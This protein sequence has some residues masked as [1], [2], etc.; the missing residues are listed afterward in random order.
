LGVGI[1]LATMEIAQQVK[2]KAG[3][4]VWVNSVFEGDPAHRAGIRIGDVILKIGGT[5]V[6]TPGRMIRLIGAFSPGQSVN[7]DILRDGR[8]EVV[9]VKLGNQ[10]KKPDK[11]FKKLFQDTDEPSLGLEVE[12]LG[13]GKGII[14]SRVYPGST[15]DG[16]GLKVGDRI[17]AINGRAVLEVIE[18]IDFLDA[19]SGEG[20]IHLLVLRNKNK[21][22]FELTQRS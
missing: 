2:G 4:G 11:V 17:E 16:Q 20:K 18:F 19:A 9:T 21:F 5:A 8:R 14:V 6:D 22:H 7:L 15:A 1:E 12:S 13:G 10:K 3:K